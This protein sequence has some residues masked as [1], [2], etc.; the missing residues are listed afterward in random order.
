MYGDRL[1]LYDKRA[2]MFFVCFTK[3][4]TMKRGASVKAIWVQ[5]MSVAW[6][7]SNLS[8]IQK[9][10]RELGPDVKIVTETQAR[11]IMEMRALDEEYARVNNV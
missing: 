3:H 2:D 11:R 1:M 4:W 5:D 9:K 8:S 6:V 7:T 10:R